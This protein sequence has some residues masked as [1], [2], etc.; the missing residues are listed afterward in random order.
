[1]TSEGLTHHAL[2]RMAQRG[3]DTDDLDLIICMGIEVEDGYF[4]RDK[5]FQALDQKLKQFRDHLRRLVGMRLVVEG[6]R[7]V[8]AYHARRSKQRRLLRHAEQRAMQR[9]SYA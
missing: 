6:N 7:V 2:I 1:M 9:E 4:V 8:T 5:D 3:F